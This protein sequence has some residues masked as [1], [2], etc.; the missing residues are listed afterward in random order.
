MSD[1][2]Q[3][4]DVPL[5]NFPEEFK[6]K[7]WKVNW[8]PEAGDVVWG[9]LHVGNRERKFRKTMSYCL[10]LTVFIS[11]AYLYNKYAMQTTMERILT[12]ITKKA[13]GIEEGQM[14]DNWMNGKSYQF[15]K[16]VY[17]LITIYAPVVVLCMVNYG[18]LPIFCQ[19]TAM[20]EGRRKNSSI[21]KAILRR[22]YV[23]MIFN[24]LILPTLA[25]KTPDQFTAQYKG[26]M[27][28]MNML[29]SYDWTIGYCHNGCLCYGASSF[30]VCDD[31]P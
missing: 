2:S 21:Q 8:A 1:M 17:G 18:I 23:L 12:D 4:S 9:N 31:A 14:V 29:K 24:I 28:A 30:H 6:S 5:L 7:A 19:V 20:L 10:L 27:D 11:I 16:L 26:M 22:N 25:L 13:T 15:G 3:F